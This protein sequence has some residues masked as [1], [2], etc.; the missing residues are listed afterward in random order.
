MRAA[1]ALL[2]VATLTACGSQSPHAARRPQPR[3]PHA[4][5]LELAQ[6][7]EDVAAR[8]AAGD[9]CGALAAAH[10]LQRRSIT[11]L[12]RIPSAY[13]ETLE[14]T[15]N[16]LVSRISCVPAPV[17]VTI[18]QTPQKP[19]GKPHGRE[20]HHGKGHGHGNEGGD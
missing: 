12:P 15:I 8:V 14:S 2:A 20:K 6:L 7:S 16:D 4:V 17:T 13:Q 1:V 5:A 9:G 10:A 18:P 19:P 11:T 3:L